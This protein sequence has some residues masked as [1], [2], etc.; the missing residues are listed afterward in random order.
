MELLLMSLVCGDRAIFRLILREE[1]DGF[2]LPILVARWVRRKEL[3]EPLDRLLVALLEGHEDRGIE[4][5]PERFCRRGA[6]H[7]AAEHQRWSAPGVHGRGLLCRR[8]C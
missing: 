5:A 7:G 3:P 8:Q 6:G 4:S 2:A 1:G